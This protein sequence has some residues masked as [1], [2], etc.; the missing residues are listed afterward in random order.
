MSLTMLPNQEAKQMGNAHVRSHQIIFY[1]IIRA[2][3]SGSVAMKPHM[4]RWSPL[5]SPKPFNMSVTL[6]AKR[7]FA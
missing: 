4:L 6:L 1:F 5:S 7:R 3:T 2:C